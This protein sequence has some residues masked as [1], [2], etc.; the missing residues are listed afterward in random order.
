MK[1]TDILKPKAIIFE[2]KAQDKIST[3]QELSEALHLVNPEIS[4]ESITQTLLDREKLGSTGIGS[5]VA[6]PHGKLLELKEIS[7]A[8]GRSS[9]G[10]DF[11]AQDGEV[12]HIFFALIAPEN[13]AGQHLKALAKL[14]RLLKDSH[15]RESL[16]QAKNAE[17]IFQIIVNEDIK[18]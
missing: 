13:S 9:Q 8:F 3:I 6:I 7:A 17:E 1:I 5:G 16:L 12:S 4:T 14:S 11:D 10:I 18:H 2:L 15:F